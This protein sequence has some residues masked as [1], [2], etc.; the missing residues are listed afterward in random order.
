MNRKDFVPEPQINVSVPE[1]SLQAKKELK[2]AEDHKPLAVIDPCSLF[3]MPV[4]D[5]QWIVQD[6]LPVGYT[7]AL[8]GDGG[9]GK[10]LVVQQLMTS[11][12]TARPWLGLAVE[13]CKV[14]GLF[15]EDDE[16]ELH[17]RQDA[18]NCQYGINFSDLGN[19]RW[20]SG[21]GANNL[22]MTF[23]RD[24]QGLRT[25]RL[26]ELTQAVKQF[27]AKLVIIDTAADTFGGNENDRSQVRQFIGTA[28]SKLARDIKGAVLLCAHPSRSGMSATGDLDGGSTA[29]SNTV[30]SRW[31]LTRPKD[32]DA[33]A[34]TDERILTRR[35]AN[36]AAKGVDIEMRWQRGVLVPMQAIGGIQRAVNRTNVEAVF[37]A[38]LDEAI[39][40]GRHVSESR[41]SGNYG[42]TLFSKSP[43][44]EGYS[45][46]DFVAALERLF[47]DGRIVVETYGRPG[48]QH[49]HIVRAKASEASE[50]DEI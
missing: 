41:N 32:D 9:L 34:D 10:T 1:L 22:L 49:R 47:S 23:E 48:D 20:V 7:T 30:R 39:K 16:D 3:G 26:E 35:K 31:S 42:P 21:V 29:W 12:A 37:L 13:P 8:Y 45:K 17:R 33:P 27:D 43:H 36:Y 28:L 25:D 38:L 40:S 6:W 5:R 46:K 11:C 15:C 19:M 14:F 24:G 18:I 44:R 50:H 2:K 4:P